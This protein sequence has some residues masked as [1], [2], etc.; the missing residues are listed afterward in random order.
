MQ[1]LWKSFLKAYN[2]IGVCV[3]RLPE[4]APLLLLPV[5]LEEAQ[6]LPILFTVPCCMT[7]ELVPVRSL[8]KEEV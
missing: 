3:S 2:L 5:L 4:R 8:R 1:F 7:T 6:R